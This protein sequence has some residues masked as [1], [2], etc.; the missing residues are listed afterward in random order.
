LG[1][2]K[3]SIVRFGKN[4][5]L[6]WW[7]ANERTKI[8]NQEDQLRPKYGQTAKKLSGSNERLSGKFFDL[9]RLRLALT[10]A[11]RKYQCL[12]FSY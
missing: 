11:R 5:T 3:R 2:Q 10:P 6:G 7:L 1:G 12:W 8:A 4:T 9:R